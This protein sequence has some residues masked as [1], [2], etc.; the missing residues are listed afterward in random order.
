VM[1]QIYC[2]FSENIAKMPNQVSGADGVKIGVLRIGR[3]GL[4]II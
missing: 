1:F 4:E 3:A 2:A